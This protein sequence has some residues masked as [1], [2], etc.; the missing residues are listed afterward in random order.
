MSIHQILK[1]YWGYDH[2]RPLQEDIITSVMENYDTL[3]LLP[4]GGGKSICFQ[5]PALAK[6]G[7]CIVVSPL[8]AL[9]KDQVENLQKRGIKA[10][11]IISGMGKR[12]IDI[13]LDN[14]VYGDI[15]FLYIS[16]ERLM[17][18]LVRERIR[19]MK[20]NLFAIDESHCIS[21]WG[22]DFRP[23]Y[24]HIHEVRS[25]HPKVPVIALTASA[26]AI[27]Q[28][29]IVEKLHFKDAKIFKQSFARENLSYSVL[30]LENKLQKMVQI[31]NNLKGSG[32]VYVRTRKD[33]VELSKFLSQYGIS[34]AFYHAGLDAESRNLTQ[35]K[36]I[37]DEV[38][39]IVATNAFGMGIDKPNVRFVIHYEMPESPEAYYQEAGRGGRD[40][41]KAY[42][43]MFYQEQDGLIF[44]KRFDQSFPP[45]DEIKKVYHCLCNYLQ[46]P[47]G[48]GNGVSYNF[49]IAEFSSR[50][51]LDVIMAISAI[52]TLEANDYL[53]MSENALLPSR[54]QFL[55][56]GE[57]LYKFQVENYKYD[58]FIK[59]LL[60]I[61]GGVFE[62]FVAI[63]ESEIAKRTS[64]STT[65]VTAILREL[66]KLEVITYVEKTDQPLLTFMQPRYGLENLYIDAAYYKQRKEVYQAKMDAMFGYVERNEC[67]SQQLLR[68]FDEDNA[69]ECGICD[70]CIDNKRALQLK[71]K[72]IEELLEALRIAPLDL[73]QLVTASK[74]GTDNYRLE[75]IRVLLDAGEIKLTDGKYYL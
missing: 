7:I 41:Q 2:F 40:G 69:T 31:C 57:D 1:Q 51:Q 32:I 17:T 10:L 74:L 24:L 50:F 11:A 36:W 30:I 59:S 34:A 49:N 67:R 19:Y 21:Q 14:C 28:R 37:S 4:T 64:F 52:K 62:S 5:V 66:N 47:F 27:V 20:V 42:A 25:L 53:V 35:K 9:M 8:I 16:P 55:V 46:I 63:K 60:R 73:E 6:E 3:A 56:G 72:I 23:P 18:D 13:A 61:Y 15:K 45:I 48:A 58:F 26:T 38:R 43:V 70:V 12:E 33:T 75:V 71:S 65:E 39:V 68:Y 29:D 54:V 44:R 22:Y